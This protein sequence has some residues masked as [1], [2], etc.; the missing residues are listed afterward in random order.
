MR[1]LALLVL[2]L[3][4]GVGAGLA[5]AW[6]IQP[7]GL[8]ETRPASLRADYQ[9]EYIQ[10]VAQAFAVDGDATRA[11]TRLK[12]LGNTDP[13]ERVIAL[14]QQLL[15][16]NGDAESVR[17]LGQLAAVL[18]AAPVTPTPLAVDQTATPSTPTE[19]PTVTPTPTA[20]ATP[21]PSP[22]PSITPIPLPTLEPSPT[23]IGALYFVEQQIV[24]DPSA[25]VSLIQVLAT[26]AQYRPVPGVEVLVEW[27][28]GSGFDHFFTGL[29]PDRSPGYGDFMMSPHTV[30]TVR[31]ATNPAEAVTGLV[32]PECQTAAGQKY[33]GS[34]ALV[35]RGK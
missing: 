35:F 4:L 22:I 8:T 25:T 2:G 21:T 15:A 31:L 30:Y 1:A 12:Q 14:A 16:A 34:W 19:P 18:G 26:D 6:Y 10:L 33:A 23:P 11:R 28:G 32:I 27:A 5:Y 7:V 20:S 3:A 9:A 24:C 17:A 29:K 13:T